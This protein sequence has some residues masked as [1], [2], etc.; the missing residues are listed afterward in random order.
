[1]TPLNSDQHSLTSL[2][3]IQ[4]KSGEVYIHS[5]ITAIAKLQVNFSNRNKTK[6]TLV[7]NSL[8]IPRRDIKEEMKKSKKLEQN[9]TKQ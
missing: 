3:S 5:H 7:C 1:M 2:D 4:F 6:T 9:S 8:Q